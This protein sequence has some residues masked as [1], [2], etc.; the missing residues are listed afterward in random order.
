MGYVNHK[1]NMKEVLKEMEYHEAM[2]SACKGSHMT[3]VGHVRMQSRVCF[4]T[5]SLRETAVN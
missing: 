1:H 2:F 5:G 3:I 4:L